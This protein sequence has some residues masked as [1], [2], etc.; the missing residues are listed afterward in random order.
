MLSRAIFLTLN[1]SRFVKTGRS[2]ATPIFLEIEP[3]RIFFNNITVIPVGTSVH[4]SHG[5]KAD[6]TTYADVIP[7]T[8]V[9][10]P[11]TVSPKTSLRSSSA[12][13]S[14]SPLAS[15]SFSAN[16]SRDSIASVLPSM[17]PLASTA[18]PSTQMKTRRI[19]VM[20]FVLSSEPVKQSVMESPA[21]VIIGCSRKDAIL[22]SLK[23]VFD[24]QGSQDYDIYLSLGCKDRLSVT[25]M[26]QALEGSSINVARLHLLEYDDQIYNVRNIKDQYFRIHRHYVFLFDVLFGKFN[27]SHVLFVEDDL[28]LAPTSL[29]FI[30]QVVPILDFDPSLL[31]ISLFNDNALILL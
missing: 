29:D 27:H 13:P 3:S 25:Q 23:C 7:T 28:E 2:W 1:S 9:F 16:I 17:T 10:S 11:P 30:R 14:E 21:I 19:G 22:K 31:C 20:D 8:K 15:T 26:R 5:I 4:P 12:I 6:D 18:L 24:L